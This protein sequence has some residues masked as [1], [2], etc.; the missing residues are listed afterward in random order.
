MSDSSSDENDERLREA[1]V[2]VNDIFAKKQGQK[3]V[4]ESNDACG[5]TGTTIT[6]LSTECRQF[7]AKSLSNT[8]DKKIKIVDKHLEVQDND[9]STGIKLF[10]DST[11]QLV[12]IEE[13]EVQRP[14]KKHKKSKVKITD[15]MLASIAVTPEWVLQQSGIQSTNK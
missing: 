13:P 10:T 7:L 11:V 8:L 9:D 1:A 3:S 4:Q 15:D 2:T 5:D 14:R 12:E 6:D